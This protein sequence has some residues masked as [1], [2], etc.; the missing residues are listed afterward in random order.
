MVCSVRGDILAR[1]TIRH[2]W[3]DLEIDLATERQQFLLFWKIREELSD[4]VRKSGGSFYVSILFRYSD[5]E[6]PFSLW[7]I[8]LKYRGLL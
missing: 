5:G 4:F 6:Q 7:K 2:C 8:R 1:D 3:I